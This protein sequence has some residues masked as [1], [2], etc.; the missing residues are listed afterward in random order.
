MAPV[1]FTRFRNVLC[2]SLKPYIDC[3]SGSNV[4]CASGSLFARFDGDAVSIPAKPLYSLGRDSVLEELG[5]A[6]G[7][8]KSPFDPRFPSDTLHV[9]LGSLTGTCPASCCDSCGGID[10]GDGESEG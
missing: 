3:A 5:L 8:C 4:G 6:I 9:G 7:K 2:V 1:S 10:G